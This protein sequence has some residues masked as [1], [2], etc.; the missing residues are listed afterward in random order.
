[1]LARAPI[2]PCLALSVLAV[3]LPG[4]A[5]ATVEVTE[6]GAEGRVACPAIHGD[7]RGGCELRA[8]GRDVELG[9]MAVVGPVF[10]GSCYFDFTLSVDGSGRTLISDV[11]VYGTSPCTDGQG[12]VAGPVA[13]GD[14]AALPWPGRLRERADGRLVNVVDA[15]FDTC[16]GRFRGRLELEL[17]H[18][19][20][21]W[22][23]VASRALVGTSGWRV[24]G[25]WEL[26]MDG[27]AFG[28]SSEGGR[29]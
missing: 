21:G 14:R 19:R 6:P 25:S 26:D 3:A 16:L 7:G 4:A 13:T 11:F 17:R 1:M 8:T 24:D 12:C 2:W 10:F 5:S 28:G 18:A 23:A 20:G 29:G 22:R 9:L 15:C 27:V